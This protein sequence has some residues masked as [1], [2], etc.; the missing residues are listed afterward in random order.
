M[1]VAARR[2]PIKEPGVLFTQPHQSLPVV[3]VCST[4]ASFFATYYERFAGTAHDVPHRVES[5]EGS[6]R[7]ALVEDRVDL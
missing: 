2:L 5:Q 3:L 1:H 6:G 7:C 4:P